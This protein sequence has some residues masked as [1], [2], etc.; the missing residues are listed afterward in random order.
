MM[1]I[2]KNKITVV[3]SYDA[4]NIQSDEL[5]SQEINETI[6]GLMNSLRTQV[7][8]AQVTVKFQNF[9]LKSQN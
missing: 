6:S 7:N 3:I 1:K 9:T 4:L 5:A 8:N 2:M